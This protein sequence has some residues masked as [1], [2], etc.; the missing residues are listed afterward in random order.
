[1]RFHSGPLPRAFAV[2]MGLAALAGLI[3][4][5]PAPALAV[6]TPQSVVVNPDPSDWTPQIQDGEVDAILQVGTKVIVG[7][8]FTQVRKFDTSAILT[9]N[10]LFAF[11]M[12]TGVIDPNFVPQLDKAV[13]SLAPAPDGTSVF[14]GGN[15]S[16]VNG[17]SFKKLVRIRISDGQ[18]ISGFKA[19][20]NAKVQDLE[21]NNG[22][23]YVAGNFTQIKSTARSGLARLDP[24]T[25][26]VDPNLDLPFT[27][28]LRGVL[29][30]EEMDVSADGSKL[31]A[32]GAFGKVAGLDRVQAAVLDVGTVPATV[33]SWQTSDY[34][35]YVPGSTTTWCSSSFTSYMRSVKISP[36]G[37]YF[38]IATTGAFRA[39]RLCD[40]ASRWELNA[41]G[42]NQH[43]TWTDWSGGDTTWS[44]GLTGT[45]V[46]LGGHFRWWNNP[47]AG[48]S[49]GP[50][51][52]ARE[53]IAALDPL[54]G[55]PFSWNPSHERGEGIFTLPSTPDG[56][57]AGSDTDHAGGEFHQKIS[58]FPTAGGVAPPQIIPYTLPGELYNM[59]Q[60]S[61]ALNRRS[62]DGSTFGST[63][64]VPGI[65]WQNARG[66][67][68][69]NGKLYYGMSDGWLYSRTFDGST[70]GAQTQLDLHGLQNQP[71]SSF[72]IP[73]TSTRV[74]AFT[75]DVAAMTGMF[76]DHGRIYYTVSKNGAQQTTN[77]NKLYY[78]YF[79]PESGIVGASLFVASSYP[80]DPAVQWGNVRGMTLASGKLI[81]ALTD[82][83]LYSINWDGTKPTGSPTQIS[84]ATTWQSRGMFVF[85]PTVPDTTPPTVPGT[86]AGQSPT[87]GKI[88]LNW[89]PSTDQSPPITYRIYRDGGNTPIGTTTDTSFEDQGLTPGSVHTYTVDAVDA[90]DN[91]SAMSPASD[92]IAVASFTA[93]I[94]ADDFT[95]GDFSNWTSNTALSIDAGQGSPTTP[96]AIGNPTAEV[97]FASRD[98]TSTFA[99]A[100]MSANVNVTTLAGNS[101]DLFRLRSA[102]SGPIVKTFVNASGTLF[103]RSDF[104][105]TQQGSGV[106][107]G[108]GW[109]TVELCGTV[110]SAGTWDLYR[111]G[112]KIVDAWTADTGTDPIGRAQIG[113]AAAKTWTINFDHVRLDQ[114]PGD[115]TIPDTTVPTTPGK[116]SGSSQSQGT[117]DV[118]WTASFD[119]S[120]PITY[121]IYR[122]GGNTPIGSTTDTS[123]ED[124]GL[125]AGSTHTYRI[126]AVDVATNTSALSPASDPITV[127]SAATFAEDFASGDFSNWTAVTRLT[128]DTGQGSPN[129]PSAVGNPS[130][131]SAFA[132]RDLGS[133]LP[134]A[135]FSV[136][137]NAASLGGNA[138]DLFR[139]RTA[140]GGPIA[141][142]F[143]N[144]SGTLVVRSDFSGTQQSSGVSLGSGWHNVE[145]C[146]T[147]GASS[148]WDLYR[149]GVR[150]V[151]AWS[152][153][154]GTTPI[155]R[156]QIGDTNAKT[157]TVNFDHVRLDQAP[158]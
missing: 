127:E 42:P 84:S 97:A 95:T 120:P 53:G 86:P 134:S 70:F 78:R 124:Q 98:L 149:D 105:G 34:P 103:V 52:V 50:G 72:L 62:F 75:T 158:G 116:P 74:P 41:T 128:I 48:D 31:V 114:Q 157:W 55:L 49:A 88:Q 29:G 152:A 8:T 90:L 117:I 92:P 46:Y 108:S 148:T 61:G 9:R 93:P 130:A 79:N 33:S 28:P 118:S 26:A 87:K 150:I 56:L 135:C 20:A 131:Q 15:F 109:H 107:L 138:M 139:L 58:F 39:N 119:D 6:D 23:L 24:N 4:A 51:A 16:T 66:A 27:D 80:T 65:N 101:V 143:V 69:L 126:D 121:R 82:G 153:D 17:A 35:V 76:Y 136:N 145:L 60:T 54:T 155:G 141:K 14:V 18:V 3:V 132:Y 47:Y 110:G 83:R 63:S 96:S 59:D 115:E 40:T 44:V 147:V 146:G 123:F 7:G 140:G 81:Y 122:D 156:V 1:M 104:A 144:A 137:V 30:I 91:Q 106:D 25:G 13:T 37:S 113:D 36:D 22:K 77:N 94:F 99:S 73:G 129:A 32:I 5:T 142:S 100:C 64:S 151:N 67:F 38:V 125:A 57:W 11:D 89:S 68:M 85:N 71:S 2:L 154:T 10:Y 43:P 12:N 111:D 112:V 21:F 133:T 102:S 19:N 45:A